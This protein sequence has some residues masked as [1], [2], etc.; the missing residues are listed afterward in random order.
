MSQGAKVD[1]RMRRKQI[2][3]HLGGSSPNYPA[4]YH[5]RLQ[6]G[7]MMIAVAE[8]CFHN[9]QPLEVMADGIFF[10]D[11]DSAVQLNRLLRHE[12]P[13]FADLY[14]HLRHRAP[15]LDR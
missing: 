3:P 12:A 8:Q 5:R 13:G 14:L 1:D 2:P 6:P 10:R 7:H 11:A 9:A 4:M 15:P